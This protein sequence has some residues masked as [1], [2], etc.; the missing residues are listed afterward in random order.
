MNNNEDTKKQLDELLERVKPLLQ[1]QSLNA[2][3]IALLMQ[4]QIELKILDMALQNKVV[5]QTSNHD[6]TSRIRIIPELEIEIS[7]RYKSIDSIYSAL[8]IYRK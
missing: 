4:L 3:E 8:T 6:E 1:N 7:Q 5:Q 2:Q